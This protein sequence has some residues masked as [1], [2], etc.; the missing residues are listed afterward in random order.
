MRE[1]S[2]QAGAQR[3]PLWTSVELVGTGLDAGGGTW[4]PT[5]VPGLGIQFE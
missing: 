3:A 5:S 4:V 1:G 2:G